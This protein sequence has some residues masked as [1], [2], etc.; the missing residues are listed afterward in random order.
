MEWHD[1]CNLGR[2]KEIRMRKTVLISV[3]ILIGTAFVAAQHLNS[4]EAPVKGTLTVA[5]DVMLGTSVLPAGVYEY[6]CDRNNITFSKPNYGKEVLKV[7][8][9]GTELAEPSP[10]T[11]MVVTSNPAGQKVVSKLLLKGSTI[12]HVF[13]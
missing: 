1:G 9:K 3:V 10:E 12:E 5:S 7:E 8:C 6:K 4:N 13:Q 2:F 11:I